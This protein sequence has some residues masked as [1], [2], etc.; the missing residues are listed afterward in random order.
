MISKIKVLIVFFLFF[1]LNRNQKD[2]VCSAVKN[3]AFMQINLIIM[4]N[5]IKNF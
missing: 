5:L 3:N 4:I 1:Y 2:Y